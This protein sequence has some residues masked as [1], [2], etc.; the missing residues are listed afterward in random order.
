MKSA[1]PRPVVADLDLIVDDLR[2]T[3]SELTWHLCPAAR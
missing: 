1:T 2:S 3:R